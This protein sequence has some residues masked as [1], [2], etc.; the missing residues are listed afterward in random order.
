VTAVLFT[1]AGARSEIVRAFR[2]AGA[3]TI[4]TDV[5]RKAPALYAADVAEVMPAYGPAYIDCLSELVEVYDVDLILPLT[6][7]D[8]LTLSANRD[9]FDALVL[10]PAADIVQRSN[11]KLLAHEFLTSHEIGSPATW[12]PGTLPEE[13]PY[14]VFLK[15]RFGEGSKQLATAHNA[16]ELQV[17]L[18]LMDAEPIVQELCRGEEFSI[19]VFCDLSSTCINAIPRTMIESRGGESVKGATIEDRDLVRLGRDV[20]ESFGV[21]GPATIQCFREPDGRHLITDINLRFGGAFPLPTA[22]GSLY[23]EASLALARGESLEPRIGEYEVDVFMSCYA[24]QVILQ[25]TGDDL[26]PHQPRLARKLG[27]S[28]HEVA[29]EVSARF[30]DPTIVID[31]S[32]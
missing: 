19:D 2:R 17:L 10:L 23:P 18:G 31:D 15:L 1:F 13:L 3:T 20:A 27:A 28:D 32:H 24:T 16:L 8:Q 7:L 21:V 22:A 14:P 6:D 5:S 26:A 29:D 25:G 12:T 30:N 9:R 11:D 4:A